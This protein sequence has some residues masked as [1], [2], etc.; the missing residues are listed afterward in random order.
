MNRLFALIFALAASLLLMFPAHAQ[1]NTGKTTRTDL[2][3]EL[4]KL[5]TQGGNCRVTFVANNRT[6]KAIGG[7]GYEVVLFDTD[8]GVSRMT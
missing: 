4:N 5:A 2:Q 8:G 1:S 7:V 6:G 3:L